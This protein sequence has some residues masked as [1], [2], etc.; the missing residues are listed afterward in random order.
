MNDRVIM[1]QF[2]QIGDLEDVIE[3]MGER[4]NLET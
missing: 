4:Q 2:C 3:K 1:S